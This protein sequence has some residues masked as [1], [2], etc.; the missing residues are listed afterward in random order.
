MIERVGLAFSS[1]R[2]VGSRKSLITSTTA[3]TLPDWRSQARLRIDNG[4]ASTSADVQVGVM[5]MSRCNLRI[6]GKHEG[7]VRCLQSCGHLF[8]LLGILNQ[9]E[10]FLWGLD[11]KEENSSSR[12]PRGR[13]NL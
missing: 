13:Q 1:A 2:L 4:P 8:G 5:M 12:C 6:S 9:D 10:L 7:N 11:S 3:K